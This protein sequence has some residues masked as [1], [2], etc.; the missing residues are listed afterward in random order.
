MARR[1]EWKGWQAAEVPF[2]ELQRT[3]E[4]ARIIVCGTPDV[5]RLEPTTGWYVGKLD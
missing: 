5:F 1:K 4:V 3:W 2:Q